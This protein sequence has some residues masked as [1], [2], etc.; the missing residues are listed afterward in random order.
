MLTTYNVVSQDGYIA[1]KDGSEDFIPDELWGDFLAV[2]KKYGVV[3]MGRITYETIQAYPTE[4]VENFESSDIKKVV[5]TKNS[6]FVPKPG[7]FALHSLEEVLSLGDNILLSSGPSLNTHALEQGLIDKVIQNVLPEKIGGGIK[8]F[9]GETCLELVSEECKADG[10]LLR[11][12]D[13]QK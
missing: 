7:Y 3:V 8:V 1:R 12:F 13:V 10:R 6:Q 11:T 2:C 5:I 9:N 4:M